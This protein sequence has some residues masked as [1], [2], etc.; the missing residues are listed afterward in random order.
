MIGRPASSGFPQVGDFRGELNA[1]GRCE[2]D[3]LAVVSFPTAA[4]AIL[5]GAAGNLS[6]L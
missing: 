1:S 3:W 5:R 6:R 4:L 2:C